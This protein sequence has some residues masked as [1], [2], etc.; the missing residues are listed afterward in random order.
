MTHADHVASTMAAIIYYLLHNP[1]TLARLEDEVRSA[2]SQ[3]DDIRMGTSLQSC[4]FL[5]ACIDETMR[6]TPAVA[7]LLPREVLKGGLSIPAMNLHLPAGVEV[8]VPIYSIQ[9]HAAY[10]DEPFT[11][12][13]DR[14][15]HQDEKLPEH[16]QNKEALLSVF[17]PFS[18][19]HRSCLGKP[20]VYMELSIAIARLVWEYDMRLAPEQHRSQQMEREIFCGKRKANEYQV[21]DWF[22]S[23]NESV[24]V[25]FRAKNR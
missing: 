22:L 6:M 11:F 4:C 18:L 8:G 14:W 10:V 23:N 13:P 7:G 24:M 1:R 2:F 15:L 20:L 3:A 19:G 21:Q 5:R 25:E 17:C 9:H 16:R 12:D